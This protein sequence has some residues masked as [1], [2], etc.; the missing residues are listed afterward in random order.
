MASASSPP[1]KE[2]SLAAP[3]ATLSSLLCV[4]ANAGAPAKKLSGIAIPSSTVWNEAH[5]ELQRV[6]EHRRTGGDLEEQPGEPGTLADATTETPARQAKAPSAKAAKRRA[7][8]VAEANAEVTELLAAIRAGDAVPVLPGLGSSDPLVSSRRPAEPSA[9]S[10]PRADESW[11]IGNPDFAHDPRQR[12]ARQEVAT[13][14]GSSVDS[15]VRRSL[16]VVSGPQADAATKASKASDSTGSGAGEQVLGGPESS[17]SLLAAELER[18]AARLDAAYHAAVAKAAVARADSLARMLSRAT[19]ALRR[20]GVR[21]RDRR[22]SDLGG[23]QLGGSG[24]G[25]ARKSAAANP[26]GARRTQRELAASLP[27]AAAA[28]AGSAAA[29]A[30]RP[31]SLDSRLEAALK[32]GLL[33]TGTSHAARMVAESAMGDEA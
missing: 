17:G 19:A 24:P 29:S 21:P 9:S 27:R 10:A 30:A 31:D 11:I 16:L 15:R 23:P 33:S 1:G 7:R 22:T 2:D 8:E 32:S 28:G 4:A 26:L 18:D 13:G 6:R 12:A 20:A 14:L 25:S 5:S 3:G